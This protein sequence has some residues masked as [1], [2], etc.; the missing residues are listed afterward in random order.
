M[1][2]D[3]G[4]RQAV[5]TGVGVVSTRGSGVDPFWGAIAAGEPAGRMW[6]PDD[7]ERSFLAAALPDDYRAHPEIPRNLAHFLD[8]GSLLALDAALQ[9]IAA[10][11]LGT[12]AG[13]S[14]RFG[15]TDGLAYR[16][17]GQPTLFVPYGQLVARALGVRGP[18]TCT[19]GNESAGMTAIATAV[20]MVHRNQVDVVVAGA[21]QALQS[22]V[23]EQLRS[24]GMS[25]MDLARPFDERHTGMMPAEG[26]AYIVIEDEGTA[27]E[28]G[29]TILANIAGVGEVFDPGVEP[30]DVSDAPD[31][32]RAMQAALAD[33]SFLQNQVDLI[34]SC[35]DGRERIDFAEGYGI[36][37]TFGRHAY[38]AGVTTAAASAG[39]ALG[40]SGPLSVALALE[41]MRQQQAPPIAGFEQ[42]E[43]DLDLAYIRELRAEH[44]DCVLVTSL[45]MGGT[46]VSLVLQKPETD[47]RA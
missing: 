11:G 37:R 16:A 3:A 35:A 23:L 20:N 28:R 40:A 30:L 31:A 47:Q 17:P 6:T 46:N 14:R 38:Y 4:T 1:T 19:G 41:A 42:H 5:V 32:G 34:V 9:A 44:I 10:A 27:R 2:S 43:E 29:A 7:S 18:V 39:H 36:K 25:T 8:R 26:A 15:L 21:A 33:A 12:G 45:G 22:N 24:Q 13:D